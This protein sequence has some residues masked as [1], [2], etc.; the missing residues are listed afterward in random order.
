MSKPSPLEKLVI[1]K[2]KSRSLKLDQVMGYFNSMVSLRPLPSIWAFNRLLRALS[3]M[4]HYPTVV[5]MCK[6]MFCNDIQPDICMLIILVNY[7]YNLKMVDLGLFVLVMIVK[8][9]LQ[10]DPYTMNALFLGLC[11]KGKV[12]AAME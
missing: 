10:L 7:L 12:K 5:S 8:L 3:K 6:M 2:C 9:G 1:D 4:K 11:N